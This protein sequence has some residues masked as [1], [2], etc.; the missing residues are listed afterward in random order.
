MS[1]TTVCSV[2]QVGRLHVR[3]THEVTRTVGTGYSVVG[4]PMCNTLVL[5]AGTGCF[6][7]YGNC[8]ARLPTLIQ[9]FYNV[10]A[11]N[12]E[13]LSRTSRFLFEMKTSG[14]KCQEGK[15]FALLLV[16]NSSEPCS[17]TGFWVVETRNPEKSVGILSRHGQDGVYACRAS[18][19][20]SIW[21]LCVFISYVP[22]VFVRRHVGYA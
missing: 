2:I 12:W 17:D 13:R 8:S 6:T 5:S 9:V 11:C 10:W 20:A 4:L 15:T 1:P 18:R 22:V 21:I 3:T 16:K 19:R 7:I 14:E